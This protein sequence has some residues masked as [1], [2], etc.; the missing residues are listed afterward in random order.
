MTSARDAIVGDASGDVADRADIDVSRAEEGAP[1][2]TQSI[3]R[4]RL[5]MLVRRVPLDYVVG[6]AVL[7]AYAA[8]QL[9]LLE[10]PRPFDSAKYFDTAVDFP[11]VPADLFTLRIGLVAPVRLAVFAFGP[12]EAALYAVPIAAG[13]LLAASVY[14]TMLLLFH[15][16]ALAALAALVTVLNPVFLYYSSHIYPDALATGTFTTGVLLLA[17]AAARTERGDRGLVPI[18]ALVGAGVLFGWTYLI[19]EFSLFLIPAGVASVFLLRHSLRRFALVAGVTLATASLELLYGAVQYGNPFIHVRELSGRGEEIGLGRAQGR[20][21]HIQSQVDDLLDTMIVF[22]RLL[23]SFRSGWVYVALLLVFL[24]ALALVRD[25]RLWLFGAW[26]LSFWA[27]MS[28]VGLGKLESGRWILN[29]TNVR[30]WY[31][32]LPALAMG[33]LG[34]AWLLLQR[35]S[36]RRRTATLVPMVLVVLLPAL[37]GPGLIEFKSCADRR[38]ELSDTAKRWSE[39]RSWFATPV[40]E[41]FDVVWTDAT[42]QRLVPAY[43]ATTFGKPL[44]EG[45][46]ETFAGDRGEIPPGEDLSRALLLIQRDLVRLEVRQAQRRLDELRRDWSPVFVSS[47]GRM[48]LLAHRDAGAG[49]AAQSAEWWKLPSA[50]ERVEPGTC[51][52]N[53]YTTGSD[54]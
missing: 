30:Y 31:P 48:V 35:W 38:E 13:L 54:E 22:P 37:T 4:T 25:R 49:P 20:M 33:S 47:D 39:V 50:P 8:V 12:S 42:S 14:A 2:E 17:L 34:G 43:A 7:A 40:A 45:E 6:G 21:E 9:W 26:F 53:P 36:P 27:I 52:R 15:E 19:R 23:L 51:G 28:V 32:V 3:P 41:R 10:G 29:V 1:A 46:I 18:F 16:R 5:E 11:D 24:V 44:W